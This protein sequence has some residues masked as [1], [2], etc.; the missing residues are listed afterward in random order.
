MAST[1]IRTQAPKRPTFTKDTYQVLL[2]TRRTAMAQFA[3][4]P[5]QENLQAKTLAR[6]AVR[7]ARKIRKAETANGTIAAWEAYQEVQK[8]K[9]AQARGTRKVT[10]ELQN[11]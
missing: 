3:E 11:A 1:G 8:A 10:K 2:D 5:S 7:D 9:R 4:D 6:K